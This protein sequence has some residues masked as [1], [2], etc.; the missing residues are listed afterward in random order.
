MG[1]L[2][3]ITQ[4][5]SLLSFA[6]CLL[7][8]LLRSY[9]IFGEDN[10]SHHIAHRRLTYS[11][12][13]YSWLP[14]ILI[15]LLWNHGHGG[16]ASIGYVRLLWNIIKIGSLI[17]PTTPRIGCSWLIQAYYLNVHITN[18]NNDKFIVFIL[19]CNSYLGI[20]LKLNL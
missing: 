4:S 7:R 5:F 9:N 11:G 16:A 17:I 18:T 12:I 2:F 8:T 1:P 3:Y 6:V 13:G 20:L 15:C 10:Y 19:V 14:T